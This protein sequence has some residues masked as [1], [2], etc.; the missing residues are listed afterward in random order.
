MARMGDFGVTDYTSLMALSPRKVSQLEVLGIFNAEQTEYIDGRYAE[1]EREVLGRTKMHNV[2]RDADRQFMGSEQAIKE[3]LEVPFATLDSVTRPNEVENFRMYGT[4]DSNE[5]VE[6]VVS[7]KIAHI[8]RSHA[9]YEIDVAYQALQ[10]NKVYAFDEAGN[11]I[12]GLAK[13]FST[14]WNAPRKTGAIDLTNATVNPF[15]ELVAK[16]GEIIAAIGDQAAPTGFIYM[17]N[18]VQFAQLVSHPLV[19]DAYNK[20]PSEQEP[21]RRRLATGQFDAQTFS[22]KGITVVEDLSG[23]LGNDEGYLL[24]L[25]VDD[26]FVKRYAPAN[27]IE[28]VNTVSQGSYLFMRETWRAAIIESEL[29]VLT[30][31]TRPELICDVTATVA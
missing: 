28:H 13:N 16:R 25:G 6:N 3:I 23:K 14:L 21:L 30:M 12:T 8:Q 19:E 24:P 22:H 15:D 10:N 26:M 11:E 1:F 2:S 7:K 9:G 20:Y 5:T 29:A 4:E 27:T 18:S 31:I 17:V